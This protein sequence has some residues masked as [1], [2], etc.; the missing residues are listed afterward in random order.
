MRLP[1]RLLYFL[2]GV[3]KQPLN[4]F[5]INDFIKKNE[6]MYAYFYLLNKAIKAQECDP[7]S[8]TGE[9]QRGFQKEYRSPLPEKEYNILLLPSTFPNP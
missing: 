5:S 6:K 7:A 9:P 2:S 3:I 1:Q 8:L 4:W